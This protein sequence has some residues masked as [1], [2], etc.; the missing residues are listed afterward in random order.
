MGAELRLGPMLRHVG[1]TTATIW[2]E[3][4]A[5]CTVTVTAGPLVAHADTFTVHGHHFALCEV[6]GLSPGQTLEYRV[7][8]DG[9]SVWPVPDSTHPPSV[10]RALDPAAPQRLLFGSCRTPTDHSSA[11]VPRYGVDMLRAYALRLAARRAEAT[12]VEPTALLLIGDQ[13]YAD[14]LQEPMRAYLSDRRARGRAVTPLPDGEVVSFEEY[15]ELYRQAWSDP[16]IRWLLSTLPSLMLFD[17]HDIRDDWNTSGSWRRD[18]AENPWWR[19]RVTAGLGTYWIYQHLGNL[20]PTERAK[21]P[22]WRALP[23][24]RDGGAELDAFAWRAHSDPESYLWSHRHDFGRSRVLMADTR[25]GRDVADDRTRS[26]MG[27][28][29]TRWLDEALTGDVDHLVVASTLP[30]LLPAGVHYLEAWN[31]AV[32]AGAWGERL[33]GAGEKLRRAMD[34][35]HWPAFQ[36]S[37]TAVS[38]AVLGIAAGRRGTPPAS[39]LFLSGDVHFSYLARARGAGA[40][41]TAIAQLVSSPLCNRL[42][43]MMRRTTWVAART[44][45]GLGCRMVAR[46][47]GV[48][49]PA[50]R[51]RLDEGPWYDNTLATLTLDGRA[52]SVRWEHSPA[53]RSTLRRPLDPSPR[54]GVRVLA[55]HSLTP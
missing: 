1:E 22:M 18:I 42:P 25:C 32:C 34:L 47:A 26:I 55:E 23:A 33:R 48:R 5:P 46:L 43:P 35:E 53:V 28:R 37:F 6:T 4:D 30:F 11:S 38:A 31:E 3:T 39:V 51:W 40:S 45:T 24:N 9:A 44:V 10:L 50:L 15:A 41:G 17:D 13:V 7:L 36:R 2:V 12:A 49:S 21:D 8:L 52:A 19:P 14:E 16:D 29:G 20:S 27:A 54:P